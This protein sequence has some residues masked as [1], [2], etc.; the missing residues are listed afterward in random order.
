MTSF[1]L[2]LTD[3]HAPAF[4]GD[5]LL[6]AVSELTAAMESSGGFS[7]LW[8]A[9]HVQD[10]GPH[11]PRSPM[12]ESYVLLGALAS[13]T[14]TLRLG[15]LATSVLYRQ[16]TLLAKMV[17][18]L[19][20]LSGGRAVL[21]IGAGHP[22]TEGEQRAYGYDFPPVGERMRRLEEAL[23]TIRAMIDPKPEADAPPNWPRP[24]RPGGIPV[25]VAGSGEQRLLRIAARHADLINLSF[26]SGDSLERIPHKLDVLAAHCRTVGRAPRDIGVT[27]KAVL[28]IAR[29]TH[30]ARRKWDA[31]RQAR[32]IGELDARAGVFVGEPS[33]IATQLQPWLRSGIHHIVV[34]L[35]DA[36]DPETITLAG[37]TLQNWP[38]RPGAHHDHA[39]GGDADRIYRV[40]PRARSRSECSPDSR[41]QEL[42][43]G[44][45]GHVLAPA[46][47]APTASV[48]EQP[49]HLVAQ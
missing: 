38:T 15:V 14:S 4:A 42:A 45:L 7:A 27:Y 2:H 37:E 49:V 44:F 5:R 28:S 17:T 29:S 40:I 25:L 48:H 16:P 9:D 20:V 36:D 22:R 39:S 19:D 24:V 43:R 23:G 21:G 41:G 18:T 8:L 1:G 35:P 26:P 47:G 6:P 46:G 3:F 10:L 13:A 30:Q 31:W 33:E 32:G 34:E 12:P 11:G